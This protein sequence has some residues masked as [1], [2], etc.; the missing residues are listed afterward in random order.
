MGALASTSPDTENA[1]HGRVTAGAVFFGGVCLLFFWGRRAEEWSE[2][3]GGGDWRDHKKRKKE[4]EKKREVLFF[5]I[6][7][8]FRQSSSLL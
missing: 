6:S 5:R 4:K 8:L 7:E 1:C 2:G 3:R